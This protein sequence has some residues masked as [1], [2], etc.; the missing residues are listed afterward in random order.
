MGVHDFF[1]C[2]K[3]GKEL[4][5]T[6]EQRCMIDDLGYTRVYCSDCFTVNE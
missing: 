3:C 6:K 4:R 1:K 2:D 5:N